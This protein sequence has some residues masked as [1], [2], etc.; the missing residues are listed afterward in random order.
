[1][2]IIVFGNQNLLDIKKFTMFKLLEL[3]LNLFTIASCICFIKW[4]D[5][6]ILKIFKVLWIQM[7]KIVFINDRSYDYNRAFFRSIELCFI[8]MQSYT[9]VHMHYV[10][11]T[12]ISFGLDLPGIEPWVLSHWAA[13]PAL[14]IFWD[15]ASLSWPGWPWTGLPP[16]STTWVIG[17]IG[18]HYNT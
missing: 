11:S 1:M 10:C 7:E 12:L 18:L 2:F 17:V 6:K 4:L 16:A 14:F 8:C 5:V 13:P 15:G 9:H 3:L